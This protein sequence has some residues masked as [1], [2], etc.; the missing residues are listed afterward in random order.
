M[1]AEQPGTER[2]G[3]RGPGCPGWREKPSRG[4]AAMLKAL[5]LGSGLRQLEGT[6]MP[7]GRG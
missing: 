4:L 5:V 1:C 2:V 7:Q 6:E 3:R